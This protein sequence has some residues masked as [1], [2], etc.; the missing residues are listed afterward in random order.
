MSRYCRITHFAWFQGERAVDLGGVARDMF[1]AFYVETYDRLFDG[2]SLLCP[3]VYPEMDMSMLTTVGFV[4][5]HAYIVT[6]ILPVRIAFPCLAQSLLGTSVIIPKSIIVESFRDFISMHESSI[7]KKALEEVKQQLPAFSS[8]VMSGIISLLSR[9]NSRQ[10]PSPKTFLQQVTNVA[11]YEFLVKPT[12]ALAM[13]HSGVPQQHHPFWD[14]MGVSGL[15]SLY[16]AQSACPATVLSMIEDAEGLNATQERILGYLRQFIGNMGSDKLRTFLRFV[17]GSSVCSALKI[18]VEFNM[19]SGASRRP[20]AHTCTP[21]LE[22]P[23]TYATYTEFVSEFRRCM[24]SDFS[25][26]MDGV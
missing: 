13:I 16:Q 23:S 24:A 17:T 12:A 1:S 3:T 26:I 8:E 21:S 5:S 25:W 14:R 20:I 18:Q 9:F 6:G 4:I 10:I 7:V 19:L 15:F 11:T 22:L 2:S